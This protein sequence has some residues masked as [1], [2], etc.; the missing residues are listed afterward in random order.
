MIEKAFLLSYIKYGDNDAILHC[1]TEKYG[2]RSYFVR[3]IYSP[4]NKKKAFLSPMNELSFSISDFKKKIAIQT[5]SKI[6]KVEIIRN[7]N[8]IRV[9]SI[10]FF[11][12]EFLHQV[13]KTEEAEASVYEQIRRFLL[14]LEKENYQAHFSFLVE[15]LRGQGLAPLCSDGDFLDI[16]SGCFEMMQSHSF[17]TKEISLYWKRILL[18]ESYSVR[19]KNNLKEDFLDSVL[20]YYHHHFPDFRVPKSLDV[21]KAVFS[22]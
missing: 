21:L 9:S 10:L 11:I 18:E 7:N 14:E 6:E 19:I 8:D 2:V 13:L 20:V 22:D 12:A 16:E 3:G 1:F 15:F 5:I 4:K 17:F